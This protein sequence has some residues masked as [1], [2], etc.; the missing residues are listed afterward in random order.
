MIDMIFVINGLLANG[1]TF[2]QNATKI[3]I[4]KYKWKSLNKLNIYKIIDFG[5]RKQLLNGRFA[6]WIFSIK[7][8]LDIIDY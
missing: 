4:E 7:K 6:N 8:M 5:T 3:N 1:Q 2:M